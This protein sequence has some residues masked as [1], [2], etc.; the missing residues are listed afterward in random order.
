MLDETGGVSHFC[1]SFVYRSR[2]VVMETMGSTELVECGVN[3]SVCGFEARR[4]N[5]NLPLE[6]GAPCFCCGRLLTASMADCMVAWPIELYGGV[7]R[8][9]LNLPLPHCL[10]Q[11]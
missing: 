3:Q 10:A 5:W 11:S 1:G 7:D 9:C 4:T 6:I 2:A 8:L